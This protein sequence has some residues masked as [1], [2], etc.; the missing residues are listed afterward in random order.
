MTL[1]TCMNVTWLAALKVN[2]T[3][4]M[5]LSE[6]RKGGQ[7]DEPHYDPAFG[8][9]HSQDQMHALPCPL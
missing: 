2:F 9:S 4:L 6:Q 8:L 3:A 5:Q 1:S 7:L